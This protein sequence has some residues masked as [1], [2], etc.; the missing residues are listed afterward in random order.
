M[1][2]MYSSFIYDMINLLTI[3]LSSVCSMVSFVLLS[4]PGEKNQMI[5]NLL[6][7]FVCILMWTKKIMFL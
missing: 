2:Y 6:L 7:I 3:F 1:D 4:R 5:N